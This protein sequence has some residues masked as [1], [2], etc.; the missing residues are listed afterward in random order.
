[1]S[2]IKI[3][4]ALLFA[5]SSVTAL[6]QSVVS[7]GAL[8]PQT[9]SASSQPT[10]QPTIDC[11]A[12]PLP[13]VNLDACKLRLAQA[14]YELEATKAEAQKFATYLTLGTLFVTASVGFGTIVFNIRNAAAQARLQSR[15]KAL[16]VVV[17]AAGPNTAL[18]R[19]EVVNQILGDSLGSPLSTDGV[20]KGVGPG[21][22]QNRRELLKS[23]ADHPD[24]REEILASWELLFGE[25]SLGKQIKALRGGVAGT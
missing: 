1:V 12:W 16:E 19:L 21:H 6:A 20:I 10:Q 11:K 25:T 8:M 2:I 18:H 23:L 4:A 13:V 15:L 24:G 17:S 22:D 5:L 3:V 14:E 9:Q 7:D